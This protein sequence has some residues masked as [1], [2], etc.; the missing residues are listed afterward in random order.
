M[1]T[2][3]ISWSDIN[4]QIKA[5]RKQGNP[6]ANLIY[7]INFEKNQCSLLLDAVDE[8]EETSIID[9]KFLNNENPV[10]KV[11]VDL[12]ITANLNVRKFYEI[13]KKT[14]VKIGKTTEAKHAAVK[15]A[16][17]TANKELEKF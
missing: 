11:D 17:N 2:S 1:L 4:R 12:S 5:E 9:D 6:L 8:D 10:I 13:K 7:D 15:Q 16:Q 3:G 14:D